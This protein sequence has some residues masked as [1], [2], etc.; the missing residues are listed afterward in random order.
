MSKLSKYFTLEEAMRSRI[1]KEEGIDNTPSPLIIDNLKYFLTGYMDK[2]RELF[3]V[4]ISPTSVYRC[5]RLNS[6]PRV[7]GSKTS[8]HMSGLAA[9]FNVKGF[10]VRQVIGE[11]VRAGIDFD[12][13]IDEYNSWVHLGVRKDKPNRKQIL[14]YTRNKIGTSRAYV[15]IET[16]SKW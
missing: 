2:V 14:V 4:P 1:A 12:Q 6:H 16:A 15:P 11:I 8:V 10:S 5:E 13:L 9:D 7:N 3:G